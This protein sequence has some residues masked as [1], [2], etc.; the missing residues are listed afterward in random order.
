MLALSMVQSAVSRSARLTG[1]F[2][3]IS[4]FR[5]STRLGVGLIPFFVRRTIV[6]L[7]SFIIPF[8]AKII[9]KVCNRVARDNFYLCGCE[10]AFAFGEQVDLYLVNS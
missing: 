10:K 5:I 6:S 7:A 1:D 3:R 2:A 4:S 8:S 9:K